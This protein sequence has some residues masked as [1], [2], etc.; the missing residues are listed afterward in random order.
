MLLAEEFEDKYHIKVY[1]GDKGEN[2]AQKK[3]KTKYKL[4]KQS[5]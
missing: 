1:Y 2:N 3:D 4:S 5:I